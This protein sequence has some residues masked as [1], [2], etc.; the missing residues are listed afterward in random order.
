MIV[1]GKTAAAYFARAREKTA[2]V[3]NLFYGRENRYRAQP[4]DR[5]QPMG[6]ITRVD[7]SPLQRFHPRVRYPRSEGEKK[8]A[9]RRVRAMR[10]DSGAVSLRGRYFTALFCLGDPSYDTSMNIH[11]L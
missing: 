5:V 1:G 7:C 9:A 10:A 3:G 4:I 2:P 11:H 8:N 6:A